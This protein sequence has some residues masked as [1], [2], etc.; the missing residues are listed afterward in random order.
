MRK[1]LRN[2]KVLL[3]V[4]AKMAKKTK[5]KAY[6]FR[7]IAAILFLFWSSLLTIAIYICLAFLLKKK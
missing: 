4:C 3:G 1:L 5:I 7:L 2:E 6:I